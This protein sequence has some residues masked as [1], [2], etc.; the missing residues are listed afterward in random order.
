[1]L[2][3][4]CTTIW[5]DNEAGAHVKVLEYDKNLVYPAWV[6]RHEIKDA[7]SNTLVTMMSSYGAD[8]QRVPMKHGRICSCFLL[9]RTLRDCH[10]KLSL[11]C[12]DCRVDDI[13]LHLRMVSRCVLA[14]SICDPSI[15]SGARTEALKPL[16]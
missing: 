5:N 8:D 9:P 12:Y 4:L 11:G 2:P 6:S 16:E 13:R 3:P 14:G 15:L 7:C 10:P 1:M